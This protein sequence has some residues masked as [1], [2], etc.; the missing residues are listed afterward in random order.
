[1]AFARDFFIW[2]EIEKDAVYYRNC[3]LVLLNQSCFFMPSSRCETDKK[4]NDRIIECL[5]KALAMDSSLPR[6]EERRVGK[7]CS[8]PCRSR[9]SPYH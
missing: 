7:E 3:A 8:E 6:S 2:N 9:W 4:V 5:E 1:M